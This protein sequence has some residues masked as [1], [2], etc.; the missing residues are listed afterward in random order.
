MSSRGS[1][2]AAKGSGKASDKSKGPSKAAEPSP[3]EESESES[4]AL[5]DDDLYKGTPRLSLALAPH[6]A[7]PY[8]HRYFLF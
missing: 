3:E 7:S 6:R 1:S 5:I 8:V 4:L 2:R